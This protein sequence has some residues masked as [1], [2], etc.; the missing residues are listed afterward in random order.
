[1]KELKE[2][3]GQIEKN[4]ASS[5]QLKTRTQIDVDTEMALKRFLVNAK[6]AYVQVCRFKSLKGFCHNL[7]T[8]ENIEKVYQKLFDKRWEDLRWGHFP[9]NNMQVHVLLNVSY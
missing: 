2:L 8:L 4:D 5:I 7:V 9:K 1:L 3:K 6:H